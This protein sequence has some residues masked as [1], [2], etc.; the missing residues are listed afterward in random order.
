ME[1]IQPRI[2]ENLVPGFPACGIYLVNDEEPVKRIPQIVQ[3]ECHRDTV[4]AVVRE[5]SR[6][7]QI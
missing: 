7:G 4:Y 5:K 3:H 2:E 6:M 1:S